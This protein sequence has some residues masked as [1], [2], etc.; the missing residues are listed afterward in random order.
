M[1]F[2]FKL[3]LSILFVLYIIGFIL[4]Y[5]IYKLKKEK[6]EFKGNFI[7]YLIKEYLTRRK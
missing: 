4:D 1:I 3:V 5:K 2:F 7:N 6:G